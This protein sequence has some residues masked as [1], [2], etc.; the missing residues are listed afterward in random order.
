[1][2]WAVACVGVGAAHKG[3]K[4]WRARKQARQRPR[5]RVTRSVWDHPCD[6]FYRKM[7]AEEK[8]KRDQKKSMVRHATPCTARRA[9]RSPTTAGAL[10]TPL[11]RACVQGLSA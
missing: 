3:V 5:V 4:G 9:A 7:F 8:E 6:E 11:L 10:A 2:G 1:M